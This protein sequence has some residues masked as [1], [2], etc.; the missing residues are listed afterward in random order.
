MFLGLLSS[1]KDS[2]INVL[3]GQQQELILL[4]ISSKVISYT[5]T[6]KETLVRHWWE[7]KLVPPQW[8]AVWRFLNKLK[9]EPPYHP[10]ILLL[11]IYLKET[12]LLS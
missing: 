3:N 1:G 10:T 7:C 12:K 11:G 2:H 5:L 8:K 6:G 4:D 9:M